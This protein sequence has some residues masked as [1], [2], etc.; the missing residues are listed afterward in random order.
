MPVKEVA[1]AP[2]LNPPRGSS[3]PPDGHAFWGD[4]LIEDARGVEQ[5]GALCGA[6]FRNPGEITM[7]EDV[8]TLCGV[9]GG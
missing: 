9:A 8:G 4:I 6:Y 3:S 7:Q 2:A 5:D 1:W